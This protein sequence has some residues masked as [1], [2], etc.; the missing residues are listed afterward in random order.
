M[1]LPVPVERI[2]GAASPTSGA[3]VMGTGIVSIGLALDGQVLLS[4]VLLVL[5]AI[6]WVTLAVVLGLRALR[7][8][9]QVRSEAFS[10]AALTVVAGTEV[11]GSRLTLLG[12]AGAGIALLGIAFAL[13]LALL[14]PVLGHFIFPAVGAALLVTVATESLADLSAALAT[15]EHTRW[16]VVTALAPLALGLAFYALVI[17]RFDYCQLW[18]GRGDHWITGGALAISTLAAARITLACR[19]LPVLAGGAGALQVMT[20]VLWVLSIAWLPVLLS[21]E[22]THRRLSY[23]VRRWATVFPVGMYAACSFLVGSAAHVPAITD[24][25]RIA[26]WVGVAL[27]VIV[28]AA[29]L[30]RGL[31]LVTR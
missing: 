27:W 23:D 30:A 3:I 4:R 26:V 19:T 15:A 29:M 10:P 31:R 12:W 6:A 13:W 20:I 22:L 24:F 1:D 28:F 5:C 7:D 18:I 21:A 16:L 17:S 14:G 2:L 11:L 25:A 8:R 9:A